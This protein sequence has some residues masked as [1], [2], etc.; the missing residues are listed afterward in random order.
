MMTNILSSSN[1]EKRVK[2]R[3]EEHDKFMNQLIR[4][5]DFKLKPLLTNLLTQLY[6]IKILKNSFISKFH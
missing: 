5:S 6:Y 4:E 1:F 2:K 3:L